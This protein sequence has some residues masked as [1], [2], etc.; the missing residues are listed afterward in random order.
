MAYQTLRR[1][2]D[3]GAPT[4]VMLHGTGGDK[5]GFATLAPMLHPGAGVLALDGDVF[6]GGARRFFR[7]T[8]EGVYDMEDLA[9]RT[10]RLGRFLEDQDLG[11]AVGVGYSNGANILANLAITGF[12][13]LRRLVLMHP[14]IP[15]EPEWPDLT[16]LEVLITAGERD[17]IGP[18]PITEALIEGLTGAGAR[19]DAHWHPGG[20]K[21]VQSEI[22]AARDFLAA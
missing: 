10:A 12:T 22:A 17:P 20:H 1:A 14:L 13:G 21:F 5:E 19:V 3:P 2:G 4:L 8:G 16:G 9:R 6:E 7:R 18:M 11:E 15:F